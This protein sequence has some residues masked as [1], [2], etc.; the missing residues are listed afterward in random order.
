MEHMNEY[1]ITSLF[2][3]I[4]NETQGNEIIPLYIYIYNNNRASYI[5]ACSVMAYYFGI[6]MF[7]YYNTL[8]DV[9]AN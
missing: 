1:S 3:I 9:I 6:S 5:V 7:R 2:I 8:T 4:N